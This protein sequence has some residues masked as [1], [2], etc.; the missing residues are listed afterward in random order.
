MPYHFRW[1][2]PYRTAYRGPLP[3]KRGAFKQ[4]DGSN[5]L[6][7]KYW[8]IRLRPTDPRQSFMSLEREGLQ[9]SGVFIV[10]STVDPGL[11]E[12][13]QFQEKIKIVIVQTRILT[14][15]NNL[16][17]TQRVA[18]CGNRTSY[19]LHGS[20]LPSHRTNRAGAKVNPLVAKSNDLASSSVRLLLTKNH[21]VPTPAFRT[22]VPARA[23]RLAPYA[24]RCTAASCP[25]TA[26]TVQSNWTYYYYFLTCVLNNLTKVRFFLRGE[27]HPVTSP[28]L[29]EARGSVRHLLTKNHSVPTPA[30]RTGAPGV[31][32]LP[33]TGHN[34]RDRATT[35]KFFSKKPSITLPD[36]EIEPEIPFITLPDQG[37][38]PRD[39]IV[40]QSHLQPLDQR[41][42]LNNR[43]KHNNTLP[44]PGLKPEI[45]SRTCNHSTN[46]AVKV[47]IL[48]K[49]HKRP[50]INYITRSS[51]FFT[52]SPVLVTIGHIS[53]TP[54]PPFLRGEDNPM[55]TP[56]LGEARGSVRVL[57]TKIHAV[58]TPA[59]RAGAPVNPLGSPQLR[60]P[61]PFPTVWVIPARKK[62]IHTYRHAFNPR[63]SRQRCTL[64]HVMPLYNI[65]PLFT[66]YVGGK[67]SNDFFRYGRG[68]SVRLLLT[69]NHPVPT[70]AYRAGA[71]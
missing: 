20:Q 39:P 33:Y 40:R 66:I 3:C 19:T 30:F 56:A 58:P 67:S 28:T 62:Y 54:L 48:R 63:R 45:P 15:N 11:Q 52:P 21:H 43:K 57:L 8:L 5:E 12:L 24:T 35:E 13:Q 7:Q 60:I 64:W 71:P 55:I 38:E 69:K 34:S 53:E 29:G 2:K 61:P 47:N 1:T 9:C 16:W 4:R 31:S 32:L 27:N 41:K 37:I 44:E 50:S 6:R 42:F 51:C 46:E 14:R 68:G 23:E 70:P 65:H 36:S 25:I 17:I 18:P 22:G 26:L 10:V 49:T 59:F